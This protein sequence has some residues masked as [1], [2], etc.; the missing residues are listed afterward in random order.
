MSPAARSDPTARW[1]AVLA[2]VG[3]SLLAAFQAALAAGVPWGHAAW[4]GGS[5]Q[6]STAQQAA[7]AVAA[8]VYAGA[9]LTVLTR[10]GV[11]GRSRRNAPLVHWGTWFLAGAMAIGAVPNFAS[12]SRWEN[13]VLGP[14]ALALAALCTMVAHRAGAYPRPERALR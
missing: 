9:A 3:F 1:A 14:L 12:Q 7:S 13:L 4:G 11:I 8:V 2:A 5:A 10:A 6:L